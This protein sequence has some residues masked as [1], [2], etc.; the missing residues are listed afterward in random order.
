MSSPNA[1]RP[2]HL[3]P[4]HPRPL[5]LRGRY[6]GL[7]AVGGVMGTAAREAVS[8]VTPPVWGLP[9]GIFL[10]NAVGAFLLGVLLESLA[11]SGPDGGGR[12][13]MRLLLGTGA[14]GGF[15]T[16][17]AL[18]TDTA[19]LWGTGGSGPAVA[20]SLA[21]LIVGALAS[22]SGIAAAGA[23]RAARVQPGKAVRPAAKEADD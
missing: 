16:Y 12:R 23:L 19:T 20:Y 3:R 6:L 4:L 9:L 15:T 2:L 7:V 17:S 1:P 5:H 14:L 13:R 21:T 10:V 22:W 11:R 18:A 8:I